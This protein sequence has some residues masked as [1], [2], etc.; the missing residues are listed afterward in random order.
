[1]CC[2]SAEGFAMKLLNIMMHYLRLCSQ[3]YFVKFLQL[4]HTCSFILKIGHM[5]TTIW[6]VFVSPP[7]KS[8]RLNSLRRAGLIHA[9]TVELVYESRPLTIPQQITNWPEC[10]V[11]WQYLSI[12]VLA[13]F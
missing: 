8:H 10:V 5:I 3:Q 2:E 9:L 11:G 1:M 12:G 4:S 6:S 13:L 7:C